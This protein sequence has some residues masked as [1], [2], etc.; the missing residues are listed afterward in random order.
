MPPAESPQQVMRDPAGEEDA[1]GQWDNPAQKQLHRGGTA[2]W[3]P[4]PFSSTDVREKDPPDQ[5]Q[6]QMS[7]ANIVSLLNKL[8]N[9]K[10]A[11]SFILPKLPESDYCLVCNRGG[12]CLGTCCKGRKQPTK[13]KTKLLSS[14]P[15]SDIPGLDL[16]NP[17]S[18][19][20]TTRAISTLSRK[21]ISAF[22]PRS[23]LFNPHSVKIIAIDKK[24]R[25]SAH[26]S[27][28]K[29]SKSLETVSVLN[30]NLRKKLRHILLKMSLNPVKTGKKAAD[31]N[32]AGSTAVDSTFRKLSTSELRCTRKQQT[33]SSLSSKLNTS[34]DIKLSAPAHHTPPKSSSNLSATFLSST[35]SPQLDSTSNTSDEQLLPATFVDNYHQ[36]LS[37]LKSEWQDA[38]NSERYENFQPREVF[39]DPSPKPRRQQSPSPVREGQR[40]LTPCG[41]PTPTATPPIS[42]SRPRDQTP[43]NSTP[44]KDANERVQCRNRNCRVW[45]TTSRSRSRHESQ[46][47][48]MLPGPNVTLQ[49]GNLIPTH[50]ALNIDRLTCRTCLKVFSQ[51]Q[52]RKR[53][54]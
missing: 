16:I 13:Q 31:K 1:G 33:S 45:F 25:R 5:E 34:A 18:T 50:E 43:R 9:Q 17:S 47:C 44:R 48:E 24:H 8:C 15:S 12:I 29:V 27:K 49:T 28:D 21:S 51:E 46:S 30:K 54:G 35:S 19:V 4:S 38:K 7:T 53:Q 2:G 42:P 11:G 41:S 6:G 39:R 26:K 36:V 10:P 22:S 3:G 20:L 40:V 32:T 52:H 14:N 23:P 37:Y